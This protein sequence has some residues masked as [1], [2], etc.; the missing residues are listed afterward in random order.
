MAEE[1]Q[2]RGVLG[3]IEPR[4][5]VLMAQAPRPGT[6]RRALEPMLG[7]ERCAA[8]QTTLIR[9]AA[10]WGERVAPGNLHVAC[11]PPGAGPELRALLGP[12]TSIV[13]QNGVG[14]S[15]QIADATGRLFA[16]GEGPVLI[17]WPDLLNW[18]PEHVDGAL[19]DLRDG[20]GVSFGPM[21]D[22]GFYLI[23]LA[24]PLPVL[25][26]LAEDAWRSP[27]ATMLAITA[28]HGAG[29]EAGVL[30][31]ERG[32]HQPADVRAALADPL[33]EP[34]IRALLK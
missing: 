26:A 5:V 30:R 6:V 24:R 16:H 4:G 22:G 17:I 14:I 10:A 19:A 34:G 28:A 31:A 9:R 3:E 1:T 2:P 33:T 23:A 8:L 29:L 21:F 11:E 15:G 18:R 27:D 25:F 13:P 7:A 12:R 20:C 32:L